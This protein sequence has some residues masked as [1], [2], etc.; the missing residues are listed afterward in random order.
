MCIDGMSEERIYAD[1]KHRLITVLMK[2]TLTDAGLIDIFKRIRAMP[3]FRDGYS[4]LFDSNIKESKL[5]GDG[6]FKLAQSTLNDENRLAIVVNNA[7]SLGIAR[8]F[9]VCANWNVNRVAVF[10]R[11]EEALDALGITD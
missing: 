2:G 3:E 11:M 8:S 10:T 1:H 9:G 4:V 7:Y 5:T 6:V